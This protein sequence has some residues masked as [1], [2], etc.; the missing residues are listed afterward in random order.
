MKIKIYQVIP[1]LDREQ[2]MFLSLDQIGRRITPEIYEQ[3]FSGEVEADTLEDVFRIF[4]LERPEG[5]QGRSLS[6]SDVVQVLDGSVKPGCYYC[7]SVGFAP[8]TFDGDQ[9]M[10]RI[11]NH[12]F[13]G[14]YIERQR[15]R[16]YLMTANGLCS[17]MGEKVVLERCRLSRSELGYR[18]TVKLLCEGRE[19]QFLFPEK[20][21]ILA[22]PYA[23]EP[24]T[25]FFQASRE[26]CGGREGLG[27]CLK[28]VRIW[29]ELSGQKFEM[30]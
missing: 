15:V 27:A 16:V 22:T 23:P 3:V 6:V 13:H 24:P 18:L 11:T 10:E 7:D 26:L 28:L 17:C 29:L 19:E 12:D 14:L 20:P 2:K 30:L 5:Y 1:E 4:N 21:E 8:V 9:A 25:A